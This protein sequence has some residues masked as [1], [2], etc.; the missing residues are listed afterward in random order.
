MFKATFI[1]LATYPNKA[2]IRLYQQTVLPRAPSNLTPIPQP[3][4][5]LHFMRS[6]SEM[7]PSKN[8]MNGLLPL[9]VIYPTSVFLVISKSDQE[10]LAL[11][12]PI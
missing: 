8:Y 5:S 11:N 6:L 9:G 3:L 7:F 12:S 4:Y 2:H 1:L 10:A